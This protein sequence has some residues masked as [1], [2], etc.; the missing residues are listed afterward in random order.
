MKSP[1]HS[2]LIYFR[3]DDNRKQRKGANPTSDAIRLTRE[4]GRDHDNH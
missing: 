1:K 3:S 2:I 4:N